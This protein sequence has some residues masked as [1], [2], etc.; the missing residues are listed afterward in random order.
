MTLRRAAAP[1]VA[2]LV[3]AAGS[4]R[5]QAPALSGL[6]PTPEAQAATSAEPTPV[7]TPAPKLTGVAGP[8][9]QAG[10]TGQSLAD[11]V[12]LSKDARKGQ[13]PRKSLGTI[14]NETLGKGGAATPTATPAKGAAKTASGAVHATR[15]TPA[16]TPAPTYDVPRDDK[17]RSEAEWRGMMNHAHA[18]VVDGEQRVK[19]LDMK[20]RQLENDF[21]AQSDGYRRDGVIK[22]AWDK[23]RDDLAK[24]HTDLEAARKS[25]DDLSEDARRS[26][27]PPGWLR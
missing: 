25:L 22:P 8:A 13:T 19:D 5:A 2:L 1:A 27:A 4:A 10:H 21:Y 17:G 12:R 16:P 7:P 24:A 15:P 9:S 18:L 3:L 23:A 14:T 20:S 6:S 11:V 26:G